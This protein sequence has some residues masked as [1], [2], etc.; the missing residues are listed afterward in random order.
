M[1]KCIQT[2]NSVKERIIGANL[3]VTMLNRVDRGSIPEKVIWSTN[4][5]IVKKTAF[6]S[7]FLQT[8]P[9]SSH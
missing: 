8:L 7:V 4:S 3:E 2:V 6:S 9:F 1:N 5:K